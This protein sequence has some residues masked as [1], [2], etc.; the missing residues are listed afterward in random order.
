MERLP[1][2]VREK[3]GN[4]PLVMGDVPSEDMVRDGVDPRVL[5]LISGIPLSEKL[6]VGE[7]TPMLDCVHLFQRN[8]ERVTVSAEMLREEIAKTVVHEVLHY[9]GLDEDEVARWGLE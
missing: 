1:P 5:G 8:I 3:L 2:E 6:A 4:L 7:G 9:F